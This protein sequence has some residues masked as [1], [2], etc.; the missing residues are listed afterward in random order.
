MTIE[1]QL[2]AIAKKRVQDM[3]QISRAS[4]ARLSNRVLTDSPVDKG[5][6]INNWN[7][8]INGIGYEKRAGNEAG[9]DSISQLTKTLPSLNLGE[10]IT[11]SNPLPYG[12]RLE[13]EGWSKKAKDGFL[14][15]NTAL[16][17]SIVTE[18]VKKRA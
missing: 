14:R 3:S 17:D 5:F 8:T 2:R 13:Y 10:S 9:A 6:F 18:E 11:F 15:K 16:W 7:T 4:V 12:P 1:S